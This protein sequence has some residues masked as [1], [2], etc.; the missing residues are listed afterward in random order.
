MH[1][2]KSQLYNYTI[3]AQSRPLLS[4]IITTADH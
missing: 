2:T 4:T 3:F 1:L